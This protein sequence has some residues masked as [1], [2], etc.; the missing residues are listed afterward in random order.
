M[1]QPYMWCVGQCTE[2]NPLRIKEAAD[3]RGCTLTVSAS[4]SFPPHPLSSSTCNM[5]TEVAEAVAKW[6]ADAFRTS[7]IPFE[8]GVRSLQTE[9]PMIEAK[10]TGPREWLVR[11]FLCC[12]V[13]Y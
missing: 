5:S 12:V 9:H 3:R 8:L 7:D 2:V 6:R 1:L 11:R 13:R 10:R 4:V